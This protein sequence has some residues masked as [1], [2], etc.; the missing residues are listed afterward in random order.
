M[1]INSSERSIY[2]ARKA[3]ANAETAERVKAKALAPEVGPVVGPVVGLAPTPPVVAPPV[4]V[5][6]VDGTASVG[7]IKTLSIT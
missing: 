3:H 1:H 2:M 4:V 6:V 5:E 7:G